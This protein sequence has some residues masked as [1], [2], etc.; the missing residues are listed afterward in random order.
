M[1]I[2]RQRYSIYIC[3]VI[4]TQI[5]W[6]K[7]N[8]ERNSRARAALAN[9]RLFRAFNIHTRISASV[10][11]ASF[12]RCG[13]HSRQRC[14]INRHKNRDRRGAH[15]I[16]KVEC[17]LTNGFRELFLNQKLRIR[18]GGANERKANNTQEW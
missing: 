16:D 8:K 14:T 1:Q 10:F 9:H 18:S 11:A 12:S 5:R 4:A 7:K 6:T 3:A 17:I 2:R 15:K 13:M